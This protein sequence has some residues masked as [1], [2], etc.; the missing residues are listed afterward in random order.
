MNDDNLNQKYT[1]FLSEV[2]KCPELPEMFDTIIDQSENRTKLLTFTKMG[3]AIAALLIGAVAIFS[4]FDQPISENG[5]ISTT[6]EIQSIYEENDYDN[7]DDY[8]P[9]ASL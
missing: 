7:F 4:G 8:F 3:T 9:L 5:S 1:D 2:E 6:L